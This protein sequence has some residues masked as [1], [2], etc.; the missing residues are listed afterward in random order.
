[1]ELREVIEA[2][3]SVRKY[4]PDPVP[5]DLLVEM[6][7]LATQAP[8]AGALRAYEIIV[9][10][11]PLTRYGAPVNFVIC[12][13]PEVSAKRYGERGRQLY[14][15]QDATIVGA[16]LQL[17][18]VDMGL[19]TVWVGAFREG[20]VRRMLQLGNDLRPIAIIPVGYAL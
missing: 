12:A 6:V 1:M 3:H 9:T 18:A 16:Y 19:S 17:I 15:I 2:R 14:A 20:R 8:S 10:D 13:A 4:K 11:E 7:R 5:E